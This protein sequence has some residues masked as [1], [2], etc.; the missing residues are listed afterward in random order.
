M[1]KKP[2]S[3]GVPIERVGEEFSL[4][5]LKAVGR[6]LRRGK[7]SPGCLARP[8]ASRVAPIAATNAV[9]AEICCQKSIM[10]GTQIHPEA[11]ARARERE[12]NGEDA[13]AEAR[14]AL[15]IS[16]GANHATDRAESNVE[17]GPSEKC[18]ESGRVRVGQLAKQAAGDHRIHQPRGNHEAEE[19]FGGIGI[20]RLEWNVVV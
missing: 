1:T 5:R 3:L 7:D 4:L 15:P 17:S 14:R 10:E 19:T 9:A 13:R 2:S 6:L 18:R 20:G 16:V 11:Q 8:M 12:W